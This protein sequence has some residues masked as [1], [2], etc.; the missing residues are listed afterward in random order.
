MEMNMEINM[1]VHDE[2]ITNRLMEDKRIKDSMKPEFMREIVNIDSKEWYNLGP[3]QVN[4]P[5]GALTMKGY[6]L[7]MQACQRADEEKPKRVVKEANL[8]P[9]SSGTWIPDKNSYYYREKDFIHLD[10][11]TDRVLHGLV[12]GVF[13]DTSKIKWSGVNKDGKKWVITETDTLYYY[14]ER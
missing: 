10:H 2:R 14:E 13:Y 12:D 1:E 5:M 6:D 11:M 4:I 3:F 9:V 8:V 7:Y